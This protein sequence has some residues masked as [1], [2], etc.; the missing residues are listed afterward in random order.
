M[1]YKYAHNIKEYYYQFFLPF[2]WVGVL[3][4]SLVPV[5]RLAVVRHSQAANAGT[6]A[7]ATTH[8]N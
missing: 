3:R 1:L 5:Q 7:L 2:K 8:N 4:I 6:S